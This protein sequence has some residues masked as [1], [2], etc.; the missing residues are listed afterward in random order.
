MQDSIFF[1][2]FFADAFD[3]DLIGFAKNKEGKREGKY[4]NPATL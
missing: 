1:C 2:V 3:S 4:L